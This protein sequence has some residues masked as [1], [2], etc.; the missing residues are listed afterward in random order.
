MKKSLFS[1]LSLTLLSA[2]DKYLDIEPK[3]YVIPSTVEHYDL[4]LNGDDRSIHTTHNEEV[5]ALTADDFDIRIFSN[6]EVDIKNP[7]NQEFQL[8][9]WGEH[10]FYNPNMFVDSWNNAYANIYVFNKVVNEVEQAESVAPYSDS[11]KQR[12]QAEALYGR[13]LEYFF[14]VNIFAKPY[15]STASTDLSVPIIVQADVTQKG[16]ERAS[17]KDVYDFIINDLEKAVSHLPEKSKV[18]TRPNKEAGYALL[19]RVYLYKGEYEKALENASKALSIK[20]NLKNYVTLTQNSKIIAEAYQSEQ[21][22][23]HYFGYT[24]GFQGPLSEDFKKVID[25]NEDARYYQFFV[26][27]PGYGEYKSTQTQPNAATSIGEMYVTRAECY[28]RLGKKDLAIADLNILRE[29][30]LKNYEPLQVSDFTTDEELLKFCLDERRRETFQSHLRL[31]DLK[32]MNLNPA[33]AKT[34]THTFQ[35]VTYTAEPNSGKLVLPIPAQ[36]LKFN[37]NWK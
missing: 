9:S 24:R 13:A 6:Q 32:R 14:L 2:C 23:L 15:A 8:Y 26:V 5:L 37:P 25:V 12:I 7:D 11:D 21:Y 36:V 34:V 27:Y 19:S 30:R 35:G 28:T 20:G 29:N 4:L 22:A 1:I 10:R 17:V 16:A 3:G 33:F 18:L 31:F